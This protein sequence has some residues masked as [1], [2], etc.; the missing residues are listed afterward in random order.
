MLRTVLIAAAVLV[1]VFVAY[2]A[3]VDRNRGVGEPGFATVPT[4]ETV[5]ADADTTAAGTTATGTTAT[6]A[7]EGMADRNASNR[8]AGDLA[9]D[10]AFDA[11]QSGEEP[12]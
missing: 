5:P 12:V 11:A 9:T 1:I 7:T 8:A 6:G 3:M 4:D 10:D 2:S